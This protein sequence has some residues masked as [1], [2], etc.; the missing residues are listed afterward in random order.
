MIKNILTIALVAGLGWGVYSWIES[1]KQL[2]SQI[3]ASFSN[4]KIT[5]GLTSTQITLGVTLT[6]PS[7]GSQ[8]INSFTANV[9]YNN[10]QIGTINYLQP[11][12]IAPASSTSFNVDV[13]VNNITILENFGNILT[14]SLSSG[15]NI[16]IDGVLNTSLGSISFQK[17]TKLA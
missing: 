11:I 16:I 4:G 5:P 15:L 9:I 3:S 1:K 6:N 13:N 2:A 7:P 10:I 14:S 8:I 17:T 12:T